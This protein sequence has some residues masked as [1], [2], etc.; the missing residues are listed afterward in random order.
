MEDKKYSTTC[1][2]YKILQTIFGCA[3]NIMTPSF[4]CALPGATIPIADIAGYIGGFD[5][6]KILIV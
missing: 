1:N 4:D 3:Y 5:N 6:V 2:G